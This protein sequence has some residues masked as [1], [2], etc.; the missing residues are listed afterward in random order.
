M[1]GMS[2]S[3]GKGR[4]E[5]TMIPWV[6]MNTYYRY[7][8][9][10]LKVVVSWTGIKEEESLD[11]YGIG[12]LSLSLSETNRLSS[13]RLEYLSRYNLDPQNSESYPLE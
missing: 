12:S 2:S 5:K 10:A 7:A 6:G 1:R 9:R 4:E 13:P 3:S 8:H 11:G